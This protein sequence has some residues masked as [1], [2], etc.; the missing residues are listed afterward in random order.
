MLLL[1]NALLHDAVRKDAYMTDILVKDGKIAAIGENLSADG[2]EEVIDAA[3][4]DVYPGFVDAHSHLGL[5]IYGIGFEGNDYNEM[6]APICPE[7]RGIDS[8]NPF[9]PAVKM[10]LA[11][12]VTCVGT[13]P[14]SANAIGGTFL[15]VKTSGIRVDNTYTPLTPEGKRIEGLKVCGLDHGGFFNGM[16]AQYYGGLNLSHNLI[17]GWLA[18]KDVMGEPYPVPCWGADHAYAQVREGAEE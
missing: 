16:Y 14:G 12:G 17:S 10:A 5:D 18:A 1:K 3:G 4:K 13:G 15:A 8:F 6:N 2:V 9:D 11:G 7:V